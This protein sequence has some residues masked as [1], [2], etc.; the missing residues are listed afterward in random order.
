[1]NFR[2]ILGQ[3]VRDYTGMPTKLEVYNFRLRIYDEI[4][5][6][7]SEVEDRSVDYLD[8]SSDI[9]WKLNYAKKVKLD[10]DVSTGTI[11]PRDYAILLDNI[12]VE[13]KNLLNDFISHTDLYFVTIYRD[14]LYSAKKK[15]IKDPYISLMNFDTWFDMEEARELAN[16]A[17][18]QIR[19]SDRYVDAERIAEIRNKY[20][21][22][23]HIRRGR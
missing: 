15:N 18:L 9:D 1:M 22:E 7:I 5:K 4:S 23:R 17:A 11:S 19:S 21:Y 2:D 14:K 16:L 6:D 13:R 20:L 12:D 10:A 8:V 3:I